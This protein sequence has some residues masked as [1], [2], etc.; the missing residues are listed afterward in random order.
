MPRSCLGPWFRASKNAWYV[1]H[2]GR[3]T[4]L[5]VKGKASEAEAVK[6]WHRLMAGLPAE[7]DPKPATVKP[8]PSTVKPKPAETIPSL[9]KAF[10]A[11]AEGRV[12][13]ASLRN[14]RIFLEG[15]SSAFMAL[16][17][18]VLT[19]AQ[20]ERFYRR[21]EWSQSYR[22][23]FVGTV[24]SMFKWAVQTGRMERSPVGGLKKPAKQSRG[25][26]AI[27]S[28]DDHAKLVKHA[29]PDFAS[30]L[31]LLWLT[32]CRPGEVAG[33]TAQD[34]DMA[35]KCIVLSQHKTAEQTGR[36]R[37][38]VLPDEAVAILASLIARRPDGLLL[39][40]QNGRL[41]AQ[42]I[43]RKMSRLCIKAGV[44]AMA[45]GYRHSYATDAL[46]N[47]VPDATV[48]ALLGHSG[49]A[50]LHKHYS[51]LTSRTA[52]LREASAKIR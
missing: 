46:A 6:A 51:H 9:V 11:D 35:N 8:K 4:S 17:P 43:G 48:A 41:T 38:I 15:F 25:R 22:S 26:K 31:Q 3:Q 19:V 12:K 18:D 20:V 33:L 42:A 24:N 28:A 5:K 39:R 32:G 7:A 14:Y 10:L 37:I 49:T 29:S 44:K 23:G 1:W 16:D 47:G 21:P 13:P 52:A 2:D 36:D 50:M 45:Y 27:I 34:V 30:F 40:G